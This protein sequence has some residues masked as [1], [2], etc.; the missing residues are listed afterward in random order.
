[1]S[2]ILDDYI[3]Q[4]KQKFSAES[5]SIMSLVSEYLTKTHL[6]DEKKTEIREV[7]KKSND[8]AEMFLT[9]ENETKLQNLYINL[10]D[11]PEFKNKVKTFSD[12]VLA[13]KP[14]D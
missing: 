1:M 12:Y 4:N 7:I 8:F 13:D 2:N 11:D 5:I 14:Y 10:I 9:V 6:L 3:D